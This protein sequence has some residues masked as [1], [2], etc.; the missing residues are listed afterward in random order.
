MITVDK[1]IEALQKRLEALGEVSTAQKFFEWKTRTL[2]TLAHLYSEK[3]T[4]Y[5]AL[6]GIHGFNYADRTVSAKSEATELLTGLIEDLQ[7]FGFPKLN[8]TS[9]GGVNVLVNQHNNQ[10]TNVS[11]DLNIF[12]NI[13]KGELRASEIEEIKEILASDLEPKEKK[14]TFFNK[15]RSFGNDVATNILANLLTNPSV[16]EQLLKV[17]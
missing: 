1:A 5:L 2:Q 10:L 14:K 11:V 8:E 12:I 7:N 16:Y 3:H 4:C 17:L 13:I 15:I 6:D 9:N